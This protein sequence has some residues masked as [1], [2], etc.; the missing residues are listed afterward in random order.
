VA[1]MKWKTDL[2]LNKTEVKVG[3]VV[4]KLSEATTKCLQRLKQKSPSSCKEDEVK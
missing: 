4:G 1:E 2:R 3:S